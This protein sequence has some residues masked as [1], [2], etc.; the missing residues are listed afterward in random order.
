MNK[1]T[2]CRGKQTK[3]L[4]RL[5]LAQALLEESDRLEGREGYDFGK[6]QWWLHPRH[7]REAVVSYLLLTC[8]DLLGQ[9]ER[10]LSFQDWLKSN[11]N[12]Q[13]AERNSV[14][15][16]LPDGCSA[17]DCATALADQ[18]Q[19]IYGVR[20]S[21]YRGITNLHEESQD[22]LF[23]NVNLCHNPDFGNQGPN[24]STPSF[25]IAD[26]HRER[27]MKLKFLYQKRNQFTHGLEQHIT[28]SL[29]LFSDPNIPK[30]GAW[31]VE[32]RDNQLHYWGAN[33]EHVISKDNGAYVYTLSD[34]PFCL[35]EVL[36]FAI[37]RKFD[38][39]SIN[40]RFQVRL[41]DSRFPTK[42]GILN[43]VEHSA[44][45]NHQKMASEFWNAHSA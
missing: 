38:R 18:H 30:C 4:A 21:F 27:E 1:I 28:S 3:V 39:T 26:K 35:F 41:F 22:R 10:H 33:Q 20:N 5:K 29:P 37:G 36:H 9:N 16:H 42:V 43:S 6:E 17:L 24:V 31:I 44:L 23:S 14:L 40:L 19:K 2:S 25:P 8:F 12:E 45:K 34:W 13:I 32:I 7:E 15:S 11:R